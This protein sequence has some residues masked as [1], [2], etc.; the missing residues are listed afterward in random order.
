MDGSIVETDDG[1]DDMGD[2][3]GGMD[4]ILLSSKLQTTGSYLAPEAILLQFFQR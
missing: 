3:G 2:G 4:D 1:N